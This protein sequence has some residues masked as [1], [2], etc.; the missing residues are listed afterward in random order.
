MKVWKIYPFIAA[1]KSIISIHQLSKCNINHIISLLSDRMNVQTKVKTSYRG[2]ESQIYKAVTFRPLSTVSGF[3]ARLLGYNHVNYLHHQSV[4]PYNPSWCY[5]SL[6]SC[7]SGL[8]RILSSTKIHLF[9]GSGICSSAGRI[10]SCFSRRSIRGR[11]V[12]P[13]TCYSGC[14]SPESAYCSVL[15]LMSVFGRT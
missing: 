2:G 15:H 5:K 8:F 10:S 9:W 11:P 14:Y 12:N 6:L 7:P 4:C 3:C 1:F 13:L